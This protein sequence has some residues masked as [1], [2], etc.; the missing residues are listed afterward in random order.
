MLL[1]TDRSA[2]VEVANR[3]GVRQ[4]LLFGSS[5]DQDK[6][7]TDIDIAVDGIAPGLFFKF[8]GELIFKLSKPLDVVDLSMN[9][10]FTDV[11]RKEG[12]VIFER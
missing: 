3:Y 4:V 12:L 6:D 9:N 5:L 2:I 7:T 8:Y 10:S 11:I 1:E